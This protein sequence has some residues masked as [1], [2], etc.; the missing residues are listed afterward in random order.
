M[1]GYDVLERRGRGLGVSYRDKNLS[2][3]GGKANGI[4]N[5]RSG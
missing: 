3:L 2:D 5:G 1:G 4:E